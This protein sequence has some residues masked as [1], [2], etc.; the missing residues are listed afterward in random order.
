MSN[1]TNRKQL[2]SKQLLNQAKSV[3][4]PTRLGILLHNDILSTKLSLRVRSRID[5]EKTLKLR[6]MNSEQQPKPIAVPELLANL[7]NKQLM[8]LTGVH[9]TTVYRWRRQNMLPPHI[10]KLLKFVALHELDQLGWK[11][12]KIENGQLL[13]PSGGSYSPGQVEA[14][15]LRQQELAF[16]AAERRAHV[17][18][19]EQPGPFQ[20]D[21]DAFLKKFSDEL[22]MRF[23]KPPEYRQVDELEHEGPQP[24]EID[25][26]LIEDKKRALK[27]GKAR[28][29]GKP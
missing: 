21:S 17:Y 23:E 9:F 6:P 11:G 19:P 4:A 3:P 29:T 10:E 22:E 15:Q 26:W 16:Y 2:T 14:I 20:D 1:R 5:Y 8:D 7:S 27:A 25:P 13:S 18:R 28:R 12:W 24:K